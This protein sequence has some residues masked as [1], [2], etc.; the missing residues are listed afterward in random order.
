MIKKNSKSSMRSFEKEVQEIEKKYV[1]QRKL[2]AETWM[3]EF[4]TD[5]NRKIMNNQIQ[6]L[7]KNFRNDLR[8][9][10]IELLLDDTIFRK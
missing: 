5:Q 6:E 3:F 1:Y 9:K 10:K 8:N 2:L 4:D 7:E